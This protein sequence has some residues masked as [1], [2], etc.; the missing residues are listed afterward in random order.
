MLAFFLSIGL[1][2]F[3]IVAPVVLS[4]TLLWFTSLLTRKRVTLRDLFLLTAFC[5]TATFLASAGYHYFF[6]GG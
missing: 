1:I 2:A 4:Y 6:P 5:A 3:Y